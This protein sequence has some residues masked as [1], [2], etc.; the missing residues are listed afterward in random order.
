M[1]RGQDNRD[2]TAGRIRPQTPRMTRIRDRCPRL[3]PDASDARRDRRPARHRPAD[4]EEPRPAHL[5]EARRDEPGRGGRVGR[6][7]GPAAHQ[8]V[9]SRRTGLDQDQPT[10]STTISVVTTSA[11]AASAAAKASGLVLLTLAAAQFVM[12]LDMTVMNTAI[13]T[14]AKDVGT[15]VTGIQTGDHAVHAGDGVVHDHRREGR[16]DHRPEACVHDRVR[17][18]RV[19]VADDGAVSQPDGADHRLVVPGGI[20]RGADLAGDRGA[21]R[22]EL[23]K[24]GPPAR[25]RARGGRGRDGRCGRAGDRRLLHDLCLVAMGLRQRGG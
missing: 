17:R 4:R 19:R 7:R 21:R 6:E 22:L 23:R 1:S 25:V 13:A 20:R 15:D 2:P 8:P 5:R 11:T 10:P 16:R 3:A 9:R 14:V 18:V 12:A 24:A